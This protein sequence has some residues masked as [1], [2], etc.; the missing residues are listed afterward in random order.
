[1]KKDITGREDIEKL[2]NAF[3]DKVRD[4]STIGYIFTDIAK[5]DWPNHLPIMYDFWDMVLFG[6]CAYKGDPMTM[7][8][9][10]NQKVK[11]GPV[12]FDKW[13]SLFFETVDNHFEGPKADEAKARAT[14]IASLMLHRISQNA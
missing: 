7:H 1:M 3:Y 8:I 14:S 5:V 4:D 6:N 10:L 2:I 11:L 9:Q 12:Q 13:K